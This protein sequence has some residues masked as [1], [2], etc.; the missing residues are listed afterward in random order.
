MNEHLPA[1][2]ALALMGGVDHAK[3]A[4]KLTEE[5]VCGFG[6]KCRSRALTAASSQ[7]GADSWLVGDRL[8]SLAGEFHAAGDAVS[9]EGL[10]R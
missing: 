3:G 10:F 2:E 5:K 8:R 7:V 6:C 1:A 4:L 9:A